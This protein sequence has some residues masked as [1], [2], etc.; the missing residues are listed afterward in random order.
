MRLARAAVVDEGQAL[1]LLVLRVEDE[2]AVAALDAAVPHAVIGE[3]RLPIGE[4]RLA[5][6]A[7]ARAA[8]GMRAPALGRHRP[9]EEGDVGAGR[10]LPVGIEQVVGRDVVLVDGLLDQTQSQHLRVE[11]VVPRRVGGDGSEMVDAGELHGGPPERE[12]AG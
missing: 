6:D 8:D 3:T 12:A 2:P 11:G 1:A 7:K 4:R 5:R 10:G 9:V